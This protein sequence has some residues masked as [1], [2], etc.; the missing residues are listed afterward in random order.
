M[1]NLDGRTQR[2]EGAEPFSSCAAE[3]AGHAKAGELV[4]FVGSGLS[5]EPPTSLPT[6][7]LMGKH[8]AAKMTSLEWL[9]LSQEESKRAASLVECL[10]FEAL[11]ET[12]VGSGDPVARDLLTEFLTVNL[13]SR[14]SN[15]GHTFLAKALMSDP[16]RIAA[17]VTTN[18]D[19]FIE[20]SVPSGRWRDVTVVTR[21]DWQRWRK[22]KEREND[23]L[24][25]Y[26]KIHGSL[27]QPSIMIATLSAENDLPTWKGEL[28]RQLLDGKAVLFVGYSGFD[29]DICRSIVAACHLRAA[30]W[31]TRSKDSTV[32]QE[33]NDI[34]S[35]VDGMRTYGPA[36]DVFEFVARQVGLDHLWTSI[37]GQDLDQGLG[38]TKVDM[39]PDERLALWLERALVE[40][41][42]SDLTLRIIAAHEGRRPPRL[43]NEREA[44]L[45]TKARACFHQGNYDEARALYRTLIGRKLRRLDGSL[46]QDILSH[47]ETCRLQ[48]KFAPT[49]FSWALAGASLCVQLVKLK[50]AWR[51]W[52]YWFLRSGQLWEN[53]NRL[54]WRLEVRR[55]GRAF[56]LT[57]RAVR[58]LPGLISY[59]CLQGARFFFSRGDNYYGRTQVNLNLAR[60]RTSIGI[61]DR[62]AHESVM[63]YYRRLGYLAAESIALRDLAE[64]GLLTQK[65]PRESIEELAGR[66]LAVARKVGH[67]PE[68]TKAENLLAQIAASGEGPE[69]SG[70]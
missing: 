58:W 53:W 17:V 8:L 27:E 50:V 48:V 66:A 25:C 56:R 14:E 31:N 2:R 22:R 33:A 28:L 30:Y 36:V 67:R 51:D 19:R 29:F 5:A 10:P 6:A 57:L 44:I 35:R 21:D 38:E 16:P 60:L 41:G 54:L 64:A 3:I 15:L 49:V 63:A 43:S 24:P 68:I 26:F 52:G 13:S 32:A 20:D 62:A 1:R 37:P 55:S 11:M 59:L 9:G 45:E 7:S 23:R 65:M 69:S 34:L 39:F 61:L 12:L 47:L 70:C 46:T 40:V 4:V 42:N 18:Y